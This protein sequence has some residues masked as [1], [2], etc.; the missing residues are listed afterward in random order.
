VFEPIYVTGGDLKTSVQL[1]ISSGEPATTYVY[2]RAFDGKGGKAKHPILLQ[3]RKARQFHR[4]F[5][6]NLYFSN[7]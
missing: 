2:L 7:Y 3:G 4:F 5:H 1:H 6:V